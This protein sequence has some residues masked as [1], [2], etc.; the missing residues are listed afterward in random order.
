[1][2]FLEYAFFGD[3]GMTKRRD[4]RRYRLNVWPAGRPSIGSMLSHL[5]FIK[6]SNNFEALQT[7]GSREDLHAS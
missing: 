5:S 1:M 7:F 6:K 3:G 2:D 4:M